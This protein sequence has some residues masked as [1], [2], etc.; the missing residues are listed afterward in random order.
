VIL[1][2]NRRRR[3][4]LFRAIAGV[5]AVVLVA[6]ILASGSLPGALSIL[7]ASATPAPQASPTQLVAIAPSPS[8]AATASAPPPSPGPSLA[9]GA[10]L[11]APSDLVPAVIVSHGDRH[12]KVVALTFDDGNNAG[13]VAKIRTFLTHHRVNATFFPTARAVDLAPTTWLRVAEAGFP[14]GN[15]TFHH[16]SLKGQCFEAQLA[17]LEKA[18]RVFDDRALPMQGFMRPPYEEF[19]LN[20]RLAA[21]AAR[22]GYVVLWDV[23]TL[24]WTG[25]NSRAIANR[26]F[27]AGPGSIILMHTTSPSTTKALYQIVA[28][29]RKRGYTFVTIGQLLGIPGPAPFT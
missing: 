18:E 13:N 26:A 12:A 27:A 14:I 21:R 8:P 15:H 24:D 7:T 17:E 5:V 11:P 20:T 23:D 3:A 25:L 1:E 2:P 19:D 10:C 22:E 4:R 28:H 29:Y 9:P 16:E 6:A